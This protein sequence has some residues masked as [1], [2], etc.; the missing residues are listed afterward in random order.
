MR[1]KPNVYAYVK[2]NTGFMHQVGLA[3]PKV[4]PVHDQLHVPP[5]KKKPKKWLT[6]VRERPI[7]DH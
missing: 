1:P 3:E 7:T 2:N 5:R 4:Q 6:R